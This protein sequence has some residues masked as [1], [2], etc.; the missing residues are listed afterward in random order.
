MSEN[1][2]LKSSNSFAKVF[3]KIFMIKFHEIL[4]H[5]VYTFA[6]AVNGFF[7]NKTYSNVDIS[8]NRHTIFLDILFI[9]VHTYGDE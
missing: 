9:F 8:L 1:L 4:Y 5:Y 7:Q 6:L 2:Y 3:A